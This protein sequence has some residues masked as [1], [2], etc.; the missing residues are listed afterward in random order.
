MM[1]KIY[2]LTPH[3]ERNIT[4]YTADIITS[5]SDQFSSFKEKQGSSLSTAYHSYTFDE[6]Y[7]EDLN[8][9]KTLSFSMNKKVFVN[10]QYITNPF[11]N[12]TQVSSLILLVDIYGNQTFFVVTDIDYSFSANNIT[13]K[14]TCEDM[15][16][17]TTSR[18][19][20]GYTLENDSSSEDF[21]GAKTIDWWVIKHISPDCK[22]SYLYT[23]C[24]Q[25]IYET[26]SGSIKVFNKNKDG[27]ADIKKLKRII[28]EAYPDA[29]LSPVIKSKVDINADLSVEEKAQY[30]DYLKNHSLYETYAFSCSNSSANGALVSLAEHYDLQIRV[31]EHLDIKTGN[32]IFRFWFEP[33]KNEK[34]VTGLQYSP[35]NGIQNFTLGHSGKSLTTVLNVQG[36]T[37]DDEVISLIPP[38]SPFFYQLFQ[39]PSW[40]KSFFSKI[41]Y[42]SFLAPQ[43]YVGYT[44][45]KTA[46]IETVENYTKDNPTAKGNFIY[47]LTS[48]ESIKES[49]KKQIENDYSNIPDSDKNFILEQVEEKIKKTC[50]IENINQCIICKLEGLPI[51]SDDSSILS[52]YPNYTFGKDVIFYQVEENGQIVSKSTVPYIHKWQLLLHT[53]T[54]K[55]AVKYN[56]QTNAPEDKWFAYEDGKDLPILP[57]EKK[58]NSSSF[59]VHSLSEYYL[60]INIKEDLPS[61][62]LD[63]KLSNFVL[64][65]TRKF[66]TTDYEF[67][68]AADR[69]P[70]LENKLIDTSYFKDYNLISKDEYKTLNSI[71]YDDLRKI[72]GKLLCYS[73]AYYNAMHNKT[74]VLANLI[75]NFESMGA[76]CQAAIITPYE[77]TGVVSDFSYFTSAYNQ[78]YTTNRINNTPLF[79]YYETR[80]DYFNKYFNAQ[81]RFLRNVY[82]FKDFWE[83]PISAPGEGLYTYTTTITKPTPP[84]D[85]NWTLT[86][87]TFTN[88]SGEPVPLNEDFERYYDND[89]SSPTY[90]QPNTDIY[91]RIKTNANKK[92]NE[93]I[94]QYIP[95]KVV[96]ATN[97]SKYYISQHIEG[98]LVGSESFNSKSHYYKRVIQARIRRKTEGYPFLIA[99]TS[100]NNKKNIVSPKDKYNGIWL[101]VSNDEINNK[102]FSADNYKD[103]QVYVCDSS[104]YTAEQNNASSN[105]RE[106][107]FSFSRV[108]KNNSETG[109]ID[110]NYWLIPVYYDNKTNNFIPVEVYKKDYKGLPLVSENELILCSYDYVSVSE[111]EMTNNWI[112]TQYFK[113]NNLD[114]IYAPDFEVY[115]PITELFEGKKSVLEI[116][117]ESADDSEEKL[118]IPKDEASY[119]KYLPIDTFYWFGKKSSFNIESIDK[120]N[121]TYQDTFTFYTKDGLVTQ[122]PTDQDKQYLPVS[123]VT[124]ANVNK[125]FKKTARMSYDDVTTESLINTTYKGSTFS[126]TLSELLA[127]QKNKGVFWTTENRYQTHDYWGIKLHPAIDGFADREELIYSPI[128]DGEER[129]VSFFYA[130]YSKPDQYYSTLYANLAFT[131][132]SLERIWKGKDTEYEIILL[133]GKVNPN[134]LY[135]KDS[136]WT[137]IEK[138]NPVVTKNGSFFL[139]NISAI[140][141]GDNYIDG[142]KVKEKIQNK[143]LF[144]PEEGKKYSSRTSGAVWYPIINYMQPISFSGLNWNEKE[145]KTPQDAIEEYLKNSK[146]SAVFSNN[147][148][149]FF[150][151]TQGRTTSTYVLCEQRDYNLVSLQ[152]FGNS[153]VITVPNYFKSG[154]SMLSE[155]SVTYNFRKQ[156]TLTLGYYAREEDEDV[157]VQATSF[158][159]DNAY[160]AEQNGEYVRVYTIKQA[161]NFGSYYYFD[162]C[163]NIQEGFQEK[164]TELTLTLYKHVQNGSTVMEGDI[165]KYTYSSETV[166]PDKNIYSVKLNWGD[167][168]EISVNIPGTSVNIRI[169]TQAVNGV[170]FKNMNNGTFWYKFSRDSKYPICLSQA[171][172]IEA[173]LTQYW[174]SAYTASK[175]CEYYLPE[176]WIHYVDN[177]E[178]KM[179]NLIFKNQDNN[180]VLSN[181]F[182]PEVK[183]FSRNG[184][185]SLD[186]FRWVYQPYDINNTVENENE[187]YKDLT[188]EYV[189][190]ANIQD[191]EAIKDALRT[192]GED[193]THFKLE[194]IGKQTYYY[195]ESGGLYW[196]ELLLLTTGHKFERY[197]GLYVMMYEMLENYR[198]LILEGYTKAKRDH[199]QLW[200]WLRAHFGYALLE[201][202]YKNDSATNADELYN[203]AK[204][205]FLDLQLPERKYS[206]TINDLYTLKGYEGQELRTGDPIELLAEDFYDKNDLI[207]KSLK[208]YLFISNIQY[209]LRNPTQIS[210]TVNNIRYSDRLINR[211]AQ[212]LR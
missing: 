105:F 94:Y 64:D 158:D 104:Y 47:N 66:T 201:Q 14:Y 189:N 3:I 89:P 83:A 25:G 62:S 99:L 129:L 110:N 102:V 46:G 147:D 40:E 52:L 206:L 55:E 27:I 151:I 139:L 150:T 166:S 205:Q 106:I 93:Y 29:V 116:F 103:K 79:N 21:I 136:V 145:K 111:K 32:A 10:G 59:T 192:I 45:E 24:G 126:D 98:K 198:P 209:T 212:L 86:Y 9:K 159:M 48:I 41:S 122:E 168:T 20:S 181:Y 42:S 6:A 28:K 163:K 194:K 138:N 54:T 124:P 200:T 57:Q 130:G 190:P 49:V 109:Y 125:F 7:K 68:R 174:N 30:D 210:V 183:I 17:Y 141:T 22:I 132:S 36:P 63:L 87:Y 193:I 72:N 202:S 92:K 61:L 177:E 90:G 100:V 4:K 167:N 34:R 112:E 148:N 208:Q 113:D 108:T 13:Y 152:Q 2:S 96:D 191:N 73:A 133:K 172:S 204:Y 91:T 117:Q 203:A 121:K 135:I 37:Y 123:F 60:V 114:R 169:K 157:Y 16:S 11:V 184:K 118:P 170:N 186:K 107:K 142:Y 38:V 70:W 199:D 78:I 65:F 74:Q 197:S 149:I 211:L 160:F 155:G 144:Y 81:Q 176:N 67:A 171:A 77:S 97:Y 180:L 71:I 195:A 120:N 156:D 43:S 85:P 95:T 18:L 127:D 12:N 26:K 165:P 188:P 5:F 39:S 69:C 50:G 143:K 131:Y 187:W 23:P 153:E 173:Q 162:S 154:V 101:L 1:F 134:D 15:F 179:F 35:K 137:V 175:Y 56:S 161:I 58:E 178:N 185:T 182:I 128:K 207:Y 33:K 146:A 8:S 51:W 115:M 75:N 19:N 196:K 82:L 80:T 84:N 119:K 140:T 31:F 88:S 53:I 44:P 76:A 164:P